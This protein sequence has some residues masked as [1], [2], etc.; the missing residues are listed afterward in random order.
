MPDSLILPISLD[1]PHNPKNFDHPLFPVSLAHLTHE[2][3][4]LK[5]LTTRRM[6]V[7]AGAESMDDRQRHYAVVE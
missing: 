5:T 6:R 4:T 7:R 3:Q 1:L 2:P